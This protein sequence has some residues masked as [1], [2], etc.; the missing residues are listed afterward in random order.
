MDTQLYPKKNGAQMPQKKFINH[1]G[2]FWQKAH[3]T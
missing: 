3:I 2:Y 1:F